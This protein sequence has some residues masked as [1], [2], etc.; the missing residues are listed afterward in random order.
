MWLLTL[1]CILLVQDAAQKPGTQ[2]PASQEGPTETQ[3]KPKPDY[4]QGPMRVEPVWIGEQRI[5]VFNSDAPGPRAMTRIQLRLA[6][7]RLGDVRRLG[8]IVF[9]EVVD[10]LGNSLIDPDRVKPDDAT[11]TARQRNAVD[12]M[13]STGLLLTTDLKNAARGSRSLKTATGTLRV[14]YAVKPESLYLDNPRALA[15]GMIEDPRLKAAGIEIECLA[16]NEPPRLAESGRH[17]TLRVLSGQDRIHEI[18]LCD[19]WL[20]P[21]RTSERPMQTSTGDDC[22]VYLAG[23]DLTSEHTI[24][25]E[26][27][28]AIED[29]RL[30]IDLS[31]LVLP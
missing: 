17:V 15:G 1:L 11:W 6:G 12:R 20:K 21:L 19:P 28:T 3:V 23:E 16:S 7:E 9:T 10:D 31:G 25:I 8:R 30:P 13:K 22:L 5:G 26:F 4:L 2:V 24:V 29:V 14:I 18:V 27:Y